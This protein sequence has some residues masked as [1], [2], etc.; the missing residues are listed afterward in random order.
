MNKGVKLSILHLNSIRYGEGDF[1]LKK[2]LEPKKLQGLNVTKKGRLS[3]HLS[4]QSSW[5]CISSDVI[6]DGCS[7]FMLPGRA[8]SE[9]SKST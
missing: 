6:R 1:I 5:L 4:N 3:T 2:S 8:A 7:R 9:E